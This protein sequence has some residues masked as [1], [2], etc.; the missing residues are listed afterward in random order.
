M[1][2]PKMKQWAVP[3]ERVCRGTAIV[4][5]R[6]AEIRRVIE[7]VRDRHGAEFHD[8]DRALNAVLSRLEKL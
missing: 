3:Y 6:T 8:R 7:D 4:D 5:A 1:S 2:K